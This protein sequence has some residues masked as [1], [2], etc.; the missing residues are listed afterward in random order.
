MIDNDT[1]NA[2]ESESILN[3]RIYPSLRFLIEFRIYP[4]YLY[5]ALQIQPHGWMQE[6]SKKD[7]LGQLKIF[8]RTELVG[9]NKPFQTLLDLYFHS[10]DKVGEGW[11]KME[12]IQVEVG[13]ENGEENGAGEEDSGG[14]EAKKNSADGHRGSRGGEGERAEN[15]ME[16]STYSIFNIR[17]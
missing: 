17:L 13:E 12:D 8:A 10:F 14:P 11:T 5:H 9:E 16:S 7:A 6:V 1:V 4:R 15:A 3:S 2:T